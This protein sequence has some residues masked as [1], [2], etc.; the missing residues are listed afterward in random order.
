MP[1]GL[2]GG[3]DQED[4]N[5]VSTLR[6][7]FPNC[8]IREVPEADGEPSGSC[9]GAS[10]ITAAAA[11]VQRPAAPR[12]T[13]PDSHAGTDWFHGALDEEDD[14]DDIAGPGPDLS[15]GHSGG[16]EPWTMARVEKAA[17]RGFEF[18]NSGRAW[19]FKLSMGGKRDPPMTVKGMERYCRWIGTRFK[20]FAEENGPDCLRNCRTY[21]D[22]SHSGLNNEMVWRLLETLVQQDLNTVQLKLFGNGISQ[23]GVLAICEFLRTSPRSA[24]A[25]QELH[26]SHNEVDDDAALELLRTINTQRPKYPPHRLNEKSGESVPV[27]LWLQLNRN[28]IRDP[29]KVLKTARNE[30][31]TV[32][33]AWDRQACG[34]NRCCSRGAC[35]LVHLYN[36]GA[37]A[38]SPAA[39]RREENSHR[40]ARGSRGGARPPPPPPDPRAREADVDNDYDDYENPKRPQGSRS[41]GDAEWW[42]QER[43]AG[44]ESRSR[45]GHGNP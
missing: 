33:E 38:E 39:E 40:E 23:G 12:K 24:G 37:Q 28:K 26:L 14:F 42:K 35:P 5:I 9:G 15:R 10:E 25:L 31:V 19:D 16:D 17:Q 44:K 30:G 4:K 13:I 11:A 18:R 29:Q 21:V 36:F 22:F 2:D 41:G 1:D 32:C 6:D 45:R 8:T 34:T 27:P 7:M 3:D 20:S 43:Y